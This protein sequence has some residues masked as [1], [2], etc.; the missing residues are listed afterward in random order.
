MENF[1]KSIFLFLFPIINLFVIFIL[2]AVFISKLIQEISPQFKL[3]ENTVTLFSGDSHIVGSITD[4][5][6]PN[7]KNIGL[8][9][10]SYYHT[11]NKLKFFTSKNKVKQIVLGLSYHNFSS[12][13][14]EFIN[15]FFSSKVSTNIFLSLSLKEKLRVLYWNRL[16]LFHFLKEV[17]KCA[18]NLYLNNYDSKYNFIDGFNI[19]HFNTGFDQKACKERV[20]LQYY[21]GDKLRDFS[22]FNIFYLNKIIE[23]CEEKKIELFLLTTPLHQNYIKK[24]PIKFI[25]KYYSFL[26][27][28]RVYQINSKINFIN[29]ENI[30]LKDSC[31]SPDGDHLSNMGIKGF[32]YKLKIELEKYS[33][34]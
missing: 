13:Y 14:D 20:L 1:L 27:K 15:G 21:K 16:K 7:S 30:K 25:K 32:N 18:L 19:F 11:Y 29:L 33:S 8:R 31:F 23:M 2:W 28:K 17:N 34:I 5:L 10:E 6:Y 9:S 3:K 26:D 12:Y 22:D 24:V 4:T